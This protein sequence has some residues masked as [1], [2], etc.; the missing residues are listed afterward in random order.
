MD[1]MY[2]NQEDFPATEVKK[3]PSLRDLSDELNKENAIT[4]ELLTGIENQ[5]HQILDRRP[6][7]PPAQDL[8]TKPSGTAIAKPEPRDF[9]EAI[10]NNVARAR[11]NRSRLEDILNH[12]SAII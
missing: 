3:Q 4:A 8:S 5:L 7:L 12:L 11:G 6:Q 2:R 1:K 10:G 9:F